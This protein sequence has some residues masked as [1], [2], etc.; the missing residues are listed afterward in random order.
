MSINVGS[1]N[2]ITFCDYQDATPTYNHWKLSAAN[3]EGLDSA[4]YRISKEIDSGNVASVADELEGFKEHATG[5]VTRMTQ[6]CES[7][8]VASL[9]TTLKRLGDTGH[10]GYKAVINVSDLATASSMELT[11]YTPDEDYTIYLTA[12]YLVDGYLVSI[13]LLEA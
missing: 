7:N 8:K 10:C 11:Y 12:T 6:L 3:E 9:R 4:L 1:I 2:V 13:V 5:I